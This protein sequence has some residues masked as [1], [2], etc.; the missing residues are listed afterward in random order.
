MAQTTP[1]VKPDPDEDSRGSL[2]AWIDKHPRTG[3]YC[4]TF[5]TANF[6]L[7]LLDAIDVDPLWFAR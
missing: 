4:A 6:V 2:V 5:L 3:W 7:N 1:N